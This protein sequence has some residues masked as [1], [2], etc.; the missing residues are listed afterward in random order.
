MLRTYLEKNGRPAA[1]YTDRASL[2]V[3]TPKNSA[4]EDPKTLPP[5]QIGRA[6]EE[7]GIES[8]T[9]YSPQA[10]G[11]VERSF[12]TAEANRR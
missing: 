7:L 5:T 6:L 11:R 8:I 4:G 2:F 9:A 12:G 1:F 3:N 10:K